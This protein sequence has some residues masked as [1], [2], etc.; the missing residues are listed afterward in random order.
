MIDMLVRGPKI[1][2]AQSPPHWNPS[3]PEFSQINN[4]AST[5]LPHLEPYQI[6]VLKRA[7]EQLDPQRDAGLTSDIDLF[8]RQEANHYQ[9][10]QQYN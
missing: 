9:L 5:V 4:A 7:T 3:E 8:I 2:F 6:K 10:H 1:G